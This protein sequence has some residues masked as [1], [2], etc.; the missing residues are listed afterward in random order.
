MP[1]EGV[2]VPW[3]EA[4]PLQRVRVYAATGQRCLWCLLPAAAGRPVLQA[5]VGARCPPPAT[6]LTDGPCVPCAAL[7]RTLGEPRAWALAV[8]A[9][10]P[11]AEASPALA[12][13]RLTSRRFNW[14][15]AAVPKPEHSLSFPS[16]PTVP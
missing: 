8:R 16:D 11:A 3:V 5:A 1:P 10:C 9:R 15:R 7:R 12:H 4:A 13:T 14:P 2:R 6:A